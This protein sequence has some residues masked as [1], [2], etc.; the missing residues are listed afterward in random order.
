[1]GRRKFP[2]A[3]RKPCVTFG[4]C[5]HPV[6]PDSRPFL[7]SRGVGVAGLGAA[8]RAQ[9]AVAPGWPGRRGGGRGAQ[10]GLKLACH[11]AST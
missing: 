10:F 4:L 7:D 9:P 2:G 8:V 3:D 6:I 11:L 5:S 1:M